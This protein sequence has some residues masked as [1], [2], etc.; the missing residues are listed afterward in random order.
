MVL[1][2]RNEIAEVNGRKVLGGLMGVAKAG[3]DRNT[4]A[5]HH[6]HQ[7][8]EL[9]SECHHGR[10]AS[11]SNEWSVAV[12]ESGGRRNSG[13]VWRGPQ[14][15]FLCVRDSETMAKVDDLLHSP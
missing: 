15:L 12:F 5:S 9:G 8:V 6:E 13:V 4:A 11:T 3:N 7:S 1:V 14:V 10:R 2:D